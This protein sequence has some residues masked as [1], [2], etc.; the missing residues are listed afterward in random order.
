ME[1]YSQLSNVLKTLPSASLLQAK[2]VDVRAS[3]SFH[4]LFLRFPKILHQLGMQLEPQANRLQSPSLL[5]RAN[6]KNLQVN[7]EHPQMNL[8]LSKPWEM[9]KQSSS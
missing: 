2:D 5:P 9:E 3:A 8:E 4:P 7:T 1:D 6:V